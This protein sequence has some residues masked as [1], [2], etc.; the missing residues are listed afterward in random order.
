MTAVGVRLLDA[1]PMAPRRYTTTPTPIGELLLV[2]DGTALVGVH[3]PPA[4]W[5]AGDWVADPHAEPLA[6][7]LD[8]LKAYFAGD[9]TVFDLP[10]GLSGGGFHRR[11]W[12]ALADIPYGRTTS[13]GK[14]AA[15]IGHPTASR[16]VGRANG[17]NPVPIVLP[18]HRVIGA[19]GSLTGYGL[20]VD[21]KAQLL[22]LESACLF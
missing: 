4:G 3:M 16:A 5:T 15:R 20:G 10:V 11:V 9:L 7:A 12:E 2:S 19:S 8:Q 6:P 18:C 13:Y 14:L 1:D 17:Q 21:R 22:A